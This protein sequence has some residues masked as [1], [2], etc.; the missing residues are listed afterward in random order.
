MVHQHYFLKAHYVAGVFGF[1]ITKQID[2][3]GQRPESPLVCSTLLS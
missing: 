2:E 3:V 1:L